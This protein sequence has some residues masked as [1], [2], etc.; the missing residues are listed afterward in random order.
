MGVCLDKQTWATEVLTNF[1]VLVA[2]GN[3]CVLGSS[4]AAPMVN[5]PVKCG[6]MQ[7]YETT[8]YDPQEGEM[9]EIGI[10]EHTQRTEANSQLN[11][12]SS[13]NNRP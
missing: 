13:A 3:R 4:A 5:Q 12:A 8:P 2:E 9:E 11:F 7:M 1:N 6:R 10:N